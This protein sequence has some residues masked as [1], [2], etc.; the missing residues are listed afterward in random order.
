MAMDSISSAAD[1]AFRTASLLAGN[2]RTAETAVMDRIDASEGLSYRGLL[3]EALG[4]TI[5]RRTKSA[6]ATDALDLLPSELRRLLMLQPL[7]RDCFV[8]RILVGL[9]PEVCAEL[10]DIFT[11]ECEDTVYPASNQ[12]INEV[13]GISRVMLTREGRARLDQFNSGDVKGTIPEA[14]RYRFVPNDVRRHRLISIS[15]VSLSPC[16]GRGTSATG[17][18]NHTRS[19]RLQS[20]KKHLQNLVSATRIA[21]CGA[22]RCTT[23]L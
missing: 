12:H 22:A 3:I 13:E 19:S 15:Y 7:S 6:G 20:N 17:D 21:A 18:A 4:P 14:V 9:S 2:T 11:T 8:F 10:L 16:H 5:R 23:S 1:M